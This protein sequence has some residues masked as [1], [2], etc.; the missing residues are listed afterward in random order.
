MVRSRPKANILR[1]ALAEPEGEPQDIVFPFDQAPPAVI[2]R[3]RWRRSKPS[4]AASMS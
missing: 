3:Q 2:D 1:R 4:S